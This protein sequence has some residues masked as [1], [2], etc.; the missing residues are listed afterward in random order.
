MTNT[1]TTWKFQHEFNGELA[2]HVGNATDA[3]G[4]RLRAECGYTH[5]KMEGTA[6]D[7][8][9][10]INVAIRKVAARERMAV[11]ETKIKADNWHRILADNIKQAAARPAT[12]GIYR[13][14]KRAA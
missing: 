9:L 14:G 5:V 6:D 8:W 13:S 12:R 10:Q 2:M 11:L 4:L 7:G 1:N 3:R